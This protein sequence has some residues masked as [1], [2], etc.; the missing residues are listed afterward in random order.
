MWSDVVLENVYYSNTIR[1]RGYVT[2]T[3]AI[4]PTHNLHIGFYSPSMKD[5]HIGS[6]TEVDPGI[7]IVVVI[8]QVIFVISLIQNDITK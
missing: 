2:V 7:V 3:N 5:I 6:V 1:S 8:T 4:V